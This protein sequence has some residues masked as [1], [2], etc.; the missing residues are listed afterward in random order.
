MHQ[1]TYQNHTDCGYGYI[2]VCHYDD[3]CRK[4][5]Q[6]HRGENAVYGFMEKMIEEVS[7]C[8]E[9]INKHFNKPLKMTDEDEKNFK[10]AECHICN[11]SYTKKDIRVR[12]HFHITMNI[13]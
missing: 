3:K 5:L 11:K 8:L 13:I 1:K 9:T 10:K 6:V 7:Y 12:D 4:P 2:L